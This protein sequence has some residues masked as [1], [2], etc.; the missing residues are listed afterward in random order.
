MPMIDWISLCGD[1]NP[2]GVKLKLQNHQSTSS[3]CTARCLV[4]F[5]LFAT[6]MAPG[7][8]FMINQPSEKEVFSPRK[9]DLVGMWPF[10]KLLFPANW[11]IWHGG[12]LTVHVC[13]VP[14]FLPGP[15]ELGMHTPFRIYGRYKGY[16]TGDHL[17]LGR[18]VLWCQKEIHV[19]VDSFLGVFGVVTMVINN[20]RDV[21]KVFVSLVVHPKI[22]MEPRFILFPSLAIFSFF[23]CHFFHRQGSK[24]PTK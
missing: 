15:G 21:L 14:K 10:F 22:N 9:C 12:A 17:G 19:L 23:R 8:Y 24:N 5:V 2:H 11:Y 18:A 1:P 4:M 13:S 6:G 3:L 16:L 7:D 20:F